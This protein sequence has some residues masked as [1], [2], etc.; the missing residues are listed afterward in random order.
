MRTE[1]GTRA[2]NIV[3]DPEEVRRP[4]G[5]RDPAAHEIANLI[6]PACGHPR[7]RPVVDE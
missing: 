3:I 5:E 4:L 2:A 1:Q 7:D 6:D